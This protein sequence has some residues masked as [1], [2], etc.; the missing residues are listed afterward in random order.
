VVSIQGQHAK[1]KIAQGETH[2]EP[3]MQAIFLLYLI[4]GFNQALKLHG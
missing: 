2:Q 3:A 1:A 4:P